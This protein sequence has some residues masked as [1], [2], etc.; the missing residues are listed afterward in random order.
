MA[1]AKL[2]SLHPPIL[3]PLEKLLNE[4]EKLKIKCEEATLAKKNISRKKN[5]EWDDRNLPKKRLKLK[6]KEIKDFVKTEN[7]SL[8]YSLGK[9]ILIGKGKML[10]IQIAD[11]DI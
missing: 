9:Y 8:P 2:I 6:R 10:E 5:Q 1:K 11:K 7:I 3:K 4:Y